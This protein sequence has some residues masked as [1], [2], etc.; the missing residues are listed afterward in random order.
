MVSAMV[1]TDHKRGTPDG[2]RLQL[3]VALIGANEAQ[4]YHID[5]PDPVDAM[6]FRL[7]Q[8]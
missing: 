7:Q 5:L 6:K 1:D 8:L 3:L 4:N 2:D